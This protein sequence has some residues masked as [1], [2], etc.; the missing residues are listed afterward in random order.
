MSMFSE[1][2]KA[3]II[4][5]KSTDVLLSSRIEKNDESLNESAAHDFLIDLDNIDIK[6]LYLILDTLEH[7]NIFRLAIFVCNR[8]KLSKKAGRYMVSLAHRFS[9]CS[10]GN[11]NFD[12]KMLNNTPEKQRRVEQ[13]MIANIAVHNLFEVINPEF[14]RLKRPDESVG[15]HNSL[16][17]EVF[18][19]L[20]LLG[21]WK[22]ILFIMDYNRSLQLAS[23][24]SDFQSYK[25]IFLSYNSQYKNKASCLD[26]LNS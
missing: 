6:F 1:D 13:S 3:E 14:L 23:Y 8:Y 25:T 20:L 26:S 11:N 17:V 24:F 9:P 19:S 15:D 21:Y 10:A 16:G 18:R 5:I 12:I 4:K 22:K 7:Y 2:F